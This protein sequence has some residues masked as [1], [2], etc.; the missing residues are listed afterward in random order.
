MVG[1]PARLVSAPQCSIRVAPALPPPWL[2]ENLMLCRTDP[3]SPR[4]FRSFS[5]EK[6]RRHNSSGV[7]LCRW[8]NLERSVS[9]FTTRA[10]APW[11]VQ[12]AALSL[13]RI[14]DDPSLTMITCAR[15]WL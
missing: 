11:G 10:G 12:V 1:M 2:R 14:K 3:G 9:G 13:T 5:S 6:T 4:S 7:V 15:R 8:S